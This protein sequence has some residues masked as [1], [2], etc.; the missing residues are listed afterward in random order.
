MLI[1]A[2]AGG[3]GRRHRHPDQG[4]PRSLRRH[5][6][7]AGGRSN[8]GLRDRRSSAASSRAGRRLRGSSPFPIPGE[9]ADS[10][11]ERGPSSQN[12]PHASQQPS[13]R[14]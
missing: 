7:G 12:G 8:D 4:P 13:E 10:L 11:T 1:K 9:E 3:G 5:P 2:A 6:R 14:D